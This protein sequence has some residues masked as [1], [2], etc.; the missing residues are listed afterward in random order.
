MWGWNKGQ[1]RPQVAPESLEERLTAVEGELRG[2][3][4]EWVNTHAALTTLAGR[5][6]ASKRWVAERTPV[7]PAVPA[8][9]AP[10]A[11][12]EQLEPPPEPPGGNGGTVRAQTRT[13]LL[14]SIRKK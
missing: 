13:E 7:A 4:L 12:E 5:A 11:T 10:G 14:A 3:K 8:N 9:A 1:K 6:D 2:I